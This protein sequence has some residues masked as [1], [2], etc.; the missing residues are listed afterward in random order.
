MQGSEWAR[1]AGHSPRSGPL[2]AGKQLGVPDCGQR[3]APVPAPG[4]QRKA[5]RLAMVRRWQQG[6]RRGAIC[7]ASRV[8]GVTC[9]TRANRALWEGTARVIDDFT[10]AEW[11]RN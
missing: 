6:L 8:K 1:N 3:T 5:P 9:L 4:R 10:A 2:H 7:R 11:G